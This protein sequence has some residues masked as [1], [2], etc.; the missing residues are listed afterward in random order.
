MN[1][2]AFMPRWFEDN[3]LSIGQTPLSPLNW[4]AEGAPATAAAVVAARLAKR[5]ENAG[6]T[7]VVILPDSGGRYLSS[8]LFE[9]LFEPKGLTA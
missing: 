5:A 7:I 1:A 4:V 2:G 3:S 9:S 8:V 6:K